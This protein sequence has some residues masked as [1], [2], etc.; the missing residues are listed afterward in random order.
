MA[1]TQTQTV[2]LQIERV[3]ENVPVLFD[4]DDLFFSSIEKRPVERISNR[5]MRVPLEI[6]PGGNSGHYN[7]D[8][9]DLGRGGAPEFDKA[10]VNTVHLR[11]AVELTH[12][13][14]VS[15]DDGRKA[16][17]SAFKRS[18]STGMAEFRRTNEAL[19]MTAGNG[20]LATI[21]SVDTGGSKDTYTCTTDGFGVKLLRYGHKVNIYNSTLATHRTS[22]GEAVIDNIDLEAKTVRVSS[23]VSGAA[24]TDK[25]VISGVSG[26]SPTS[27]LGVPYHHNNASTG[28]WL[29]FNRANFP[30][31][32]ANRVTANGPFSLPFAR[33]ARNK[34]GNRIGM[35][36]KA[37]KLQAWMHPSQ[38]QAYE[39]QGQAVNI[40]Q[41]QASSQALDLYFGDDMQ[42]AGAPVKESFFW[43][44]TRIDFVN[45]SIWGRGVLED[46]SFYGD[47]H[48]KKLFEVRSTDGGVAA[49]WIYYLVTSY[50]VFIDNPPAASYVS[51]LTKLSGY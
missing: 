41:K 38:K 25:I 47:K 18:L 9:G 28:T 4:R 43:D 22:G 1:L 6:R 39:E 23:N 36:A 26:A 51:D 11:H 12:K 20:V 32:R 48:G 14:D 5:D 50:N 30:E 49:A 13:A 34:I 31:I 44:Q 7:P 46:I 16:V 24:A 2:A 29:G 8:G 3:R 19:M 27:M 21:T 35:D 42:M 17:L 45:L 33:L 10:V 15:T 37:K 40:I